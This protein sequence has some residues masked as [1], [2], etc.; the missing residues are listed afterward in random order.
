MGFN[1]QQ[2][3]CLSG[4]I[5]SIYTNDY[6]LSLF[7]LTSL[8]ISLGAHTLG[9]AFKDRSGACKKGDDDACI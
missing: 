2:I 6:P 9:R 5:T 1:D 3:V 7:L 4:E 8:A